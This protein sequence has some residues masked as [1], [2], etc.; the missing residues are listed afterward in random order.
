LKSKSKPRDLK[1]LKKTEWED[2]SD[3]S[4]RRT[5]RQRS[6][7]EYVEKERERVRRSVT[8]RIVKIE[9]LFLPIFTVLAA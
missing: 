2:L 4:S 9:K 7:G 5:K 8:D 6:V 1:E 3:K